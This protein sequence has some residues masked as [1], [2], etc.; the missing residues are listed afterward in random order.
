LPSLTEEIVTKGVKGLSNKRILQVVAEP[1][2][3]DCYEVYFEGLIPAIQGWRTRHREQIRNILYHRVLP[4]QSLAQ[5]RRKQG[6]LAALLAHEAY[7]RYKEYQEYEKK[8][9]PI[10][11]SEVDEA[12]REVLKSSRFRNCP[13]ALTKENSFRDF[14]QV[15]FSPDG[16]LLAASN[17]NGN[18]GLWNL[19]LTQAN[20]FK[21]ANDKK[22]DNDKADR[23]IKKAHDPKHL[24]KGKSKGKYL[25]M[26]I[27]FSADGK[28]LFS[29]ARGGKIKLWD[30]HNFDK[31]KQKPYEYIV[32]NSEENLEEVI[33]LAFNHE[34]SL[35]AAGT[36]EGNIWLFK[37]S[38]SQDEK[39]SLSLISVL[40]RNWDWIWSVA[41]NP[42]GNLLAAGGRDKIVHLWDIQN[43]ANPK[44]LRGSLELKLK[45][46][47]EIFSVAF[48]PDGNWLASGSRDH[49]VMLWDLS[50]PNE[51]KSST[52]PLRKHKEG[53]RAIAFDY[54]KDSKKSM[55]LA[56]AS[57][58]QTIKVWDLENPKQKPEVLQGHSCG[59]SSVAFNPNNPLRL[60][61]CSW[62]RTIRFWD[63]DLE[64]HIY[65]TKPEKP[66][67]DVIA[68]A[69]INED[70]FVSVI[71]DGTVEVKDY[72]KN[73]CFSLPN[74][75]LNLK[76]C[77]VTSVAFW[78]DDNDRDRLIK[79]IAIGSSNG[80]IWIS[81]I[82]TSGWWERENP[83]FTEKFSDD[84]K[85]I[86]SLAFSPDGKLLASGMDNPYTSKDK[87]NVKVWDLEEESKLPIY[88]NHPD[89]E[90]VTSVVFSPK[91]DESILAIASKNGK[92][93]LL[94]LNNRENSKEH[95]FGKHNKEFGDAPVILAFSQNGEWLASAS[96][97]IKLWDVNQSDNKEPQDI[98]LTK[99]K[100]EDNL[101]NLNYWVT[102][103][104]FNDDKLLASGR[105]DGSIQLW[106]LKN[107]DNKPI[108]LQGHEE[109]INAIAFSPDGEYLA[110]ASSDNTVRLWTVK[111]EKLAE[112][113]K[114][115]LYRDLTD[116]EK[117][118]FLGC[119][120]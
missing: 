46:D 69:I 81:E 28:I 117:K 107:P 61:S 79:R 42:E 75:F 95:K 94:N 38:Q 54:D 83:Q 108:V 12:L 113:L 98:P 35:L 114:G 71:S 53:V 17:Q 29:G 99:D 56:S 105:Y 73:K 52:I 33:S 26:A 3:S 23:V 100:D 96:D 115:K 34:K 4:S 21:K 13:L 59:V 63:L 89:P 84:K 44:P 103:L 32:K 62:D 6:D 39:F 48:S 65:R 10:D 16:N 80:T 112:K 111:T 8:Y 41:I 109:R 51:V 40:K 18:I 66:D 7:K 86:N 118:Q 90:T 50:Q 88:D 101:P 36:W 119:L 102:A 97:S 45:H 60:V 47:D 72:H 85:K 92:I 87:N 22:K 2:K 76:D 93:F 64:P 68:V 11:L 106:D 77:H 110:S 14:R 70:I 25:D 31:F 104:A 91:K 20:L 78:R 1:G 74:E 43:P 15:V 24:P 55:R 57:E 5:L 30:V 120:D 67:I 116:E 27:T 19:N 58:D 9:C 82:L 49:R 37:L